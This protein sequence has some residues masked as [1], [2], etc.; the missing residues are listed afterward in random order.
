MRVLLIGFGPFPGA[1]FN[2][3]AALVKALARRRRPAFAE[4]EDTTH[5]FATT[6]AAIDH[7]LPRLFA[8]K[9]NIIL[10]F[11]LAR[12]RRQLC[13]ETRAR[14]AVSV[15]FPDASGHRPQHGVIAPGGEAALRA[16]A[17]FAGLLGAIRGHRVPARLSRDA[18]RYLCNYAYW[19]ALE[20]ARGGRPLVQ[21][22]H[23]P[24][25]SLKPRAR[26]QNG[27]RGSSLAALVRAGEA[28]LI[29]LVAA[30]RR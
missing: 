1:P 18:G 14:N 23:I 7:D 24:P 15:L 20:S 27:H 29:A 2:P 16:A 25:V 22:V 9:P 21:F 4:I 3:S 6:Y 19:R 8:L 28:L 5:V 17:P 11:G 30:S 10:M 13:I 26:R 12:R